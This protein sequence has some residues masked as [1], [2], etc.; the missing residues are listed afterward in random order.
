MNLFLSVW[1]L[2]CKNDK[3]ADS[4]DI[5]FDANTTDDIEEQEYGVNAPDCD[6]VLELSPQVSY[7]APQSPLLFLASGGTGHYQFAIEELTDDV[8]IFLMFRE[9]L[10]PNPNDKNAGG[11]RGGGKRK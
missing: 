9:D 8:H 10:Y 1:L 11:A 5:I 2:G 3:D 7:I 6:P 4:A